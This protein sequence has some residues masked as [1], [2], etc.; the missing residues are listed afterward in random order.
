MNYFKFRYLVYI[1]RL[2]IPSETVSQ[3]VM[4]AKAGIQFVEVMKK[5]KNFA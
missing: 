4:P 3:F 2:R 1:R 5:L